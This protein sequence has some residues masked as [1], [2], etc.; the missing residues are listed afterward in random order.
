[1]Y[2]LLPSFEKKLYFLFN[3]EPISSAVTMLTQELGA[4][5]VGTWRENDKG[6]D[7]FLPHPFK[8]IIIH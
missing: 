4:D 5:I 2:H 6:H 8:F 1:M 3:H 7:L